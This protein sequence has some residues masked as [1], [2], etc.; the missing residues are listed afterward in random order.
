MIDK[1]DLSGGVKTQMEW[2][3]AYAV[4]DGVGSTDNMEISVSP[5]CGDSWSVVYSKSGEDLASVPSV[6]IVNSHIPGFWLPLPD[7]WKQEKLD[8]SAFDGTPELMIRFKEY[9]RW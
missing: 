3:Y 6:D 7:Q 4:K 5:D 2:N 9:C 1:L 8:L